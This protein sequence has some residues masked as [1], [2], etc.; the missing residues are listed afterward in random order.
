MQGNYDKFLGIN[1]DSVNDKAMK[2]SK[3]TNL[4]TDD[5]V[6]TISKIKHFE[7][8]LKGTSPGRRKGTNTRLSDDTTDNEGHMN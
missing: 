7:E 1:P 3:S 2:K 4:L 5:P 8:D 6:R